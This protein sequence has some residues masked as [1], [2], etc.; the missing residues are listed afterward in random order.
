MCGGGS[1]ERGVS[2]EETTDVNTITVDRCEQRF[3]F[4]LLPFAALT[5][6]P[7]RLNVLSSICNYR[8]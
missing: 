5:D 7:G 2:K 4:K 6:C 8:N 1:R 3:L